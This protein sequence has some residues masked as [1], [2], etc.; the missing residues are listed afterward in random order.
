[1]VEYREWFE[2]VHEAVEGELS[3]QARGNLTSELADYWQRH[4]GE[5]KAMSK[6]EARRR[7][8]EIVVG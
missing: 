6:T 5:L 4:K 7:A 1:M 8:E 3:R 2:V